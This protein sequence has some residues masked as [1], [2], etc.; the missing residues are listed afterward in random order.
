MKSHP[1]IRALAQMLPNAAFH[2][3][4]ARDWCSMTFSG[5]LLTIHCNPAN[6]ELLEY[7]GRLSAILAEHEF[8]MPGLL[9]ADISVVMPQN[10]K[11]P[12]IEALVI[13]E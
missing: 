11:S 12:I 10:S 2:V 9:V 8:S 6:A 3:I 7:H 13:N 5:Q 1:L 4:E